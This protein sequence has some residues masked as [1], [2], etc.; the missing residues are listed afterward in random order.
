MIA[1]LSLKQFAWVKETRQLMGDASMLGFDVGGAWPDTL[2][3]KSHHTG[4]V[5]Q[6]SWNHTLWSPEGECHGMV[7]SPAN[8]KLGIRLTVFST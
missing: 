5:E 7:Y 6:F 2:R 1:N 8:A 4:T 3:V